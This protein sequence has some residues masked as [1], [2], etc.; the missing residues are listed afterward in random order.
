VKPGRTGR[1]TVWT[2]LL[3]GMLVKGCSD[4][5]G[6][7]PK[8]PSQAT[9]KGEQVD[10]GIIQPPAAVRD[11]VRV[12]PVSMQV[13]PEVVM[14]PG[15]V[16]ID[17]KHMAKITSRIEGQIERLYAQLGDRVKQNQP[18]AA[19][20]SLQLDQLIEEYLVAKAQ[21]D[22]AENSFRRT[23]KLRADDIVPERKLVEDRGRHQ[24]SAV[25]F[26]HIREKLLRMGLTPMEFTKLEQGQHHEA[27]RYTL[28]APLSG[29]V[30][31]QKAVRGLGVAPG[32]DLFEIVDT[33]RVWVFANLP[34]EQARRFR[35]GDRGR[36]LPKGGEV[37]T[38]PLTYIAPVVDETTRTVRM[39]F[40][41]VNKRAYLKPG[42]FV[43]VELSLASF[44]TLA[45]PTEAVTMVDNQRG[46]FVQKES[47]YVFTQIKTGRE[48]NGWSEVRKGLAENDRVA[49]QGVFD[50]KTVLLKEHIQSGEGE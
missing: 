31:M 30:V 29:T 50:L 20:G 9:T 14:A 8:Q 26:V 16:V 10:A 43:D 13:V 7:A 22:V 11:L 4:G 39:R 36:I 3:I 42:E 28:T 45:V 15:E 37:T 49:V 6:V 40:E 35:Q 41:V 47:G 2:V 19:I 25:R 21:A 18:L 12:Q 17:L 38:A 48:G 1:A 27:H 24:E 46:V 5:E 33:S 32:D 34:I 44:P 23:E